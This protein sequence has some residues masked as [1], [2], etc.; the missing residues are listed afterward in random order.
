[1]ADDL[2]KLSDVSPNPTEMSEEEYTLIQQQ[3]LMMIP[4]ML[5]M[6]LP[7]FLRRIQKSEAIAPMLDP[8]L[9]M[10]GSRQL[11]RVKEI[12]RAANGLRKAALKQLKEE[13][14]DVVKKPNELDL[15]HL[16]ELRDMALE[17]GW[18]GHAEKLS[19][20]IA[21]GATPSGT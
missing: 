6:N 9:F 17:Q 21:W 1:M 7:G 19:V 14:D 4:F 20:M 15:K 10:K 18:I 8:T 5:R 2:T 13:L 11:E 3:L 16:A 12:A